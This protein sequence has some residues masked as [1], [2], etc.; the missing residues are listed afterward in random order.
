MKMMPLYRCKNC[1]LKYHIMRPSRSY[2][3]PFG[4][5]DLAI[6][7]S[8]LLSVKSMSSDK[9]Y[10]NCGDSEY[11]IAEL[12]GFRKIESEVENK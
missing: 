2:K 3:Y 9:I 7:E 5:E 6:D 10:H 8:V 4:K 12:V 1:G 11:G